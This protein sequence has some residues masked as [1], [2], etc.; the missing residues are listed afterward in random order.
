MHKSSVEDGSSAPV[1]LAVD[2][3]AETLAGGVYEGVLEADLLT[4][5]DGAGAVASIL[6]A[7]ITL[8]VVPS[9]DHFTLIYCF[10]GLPSHTIVPARPSIVTSP[11]ASAV[12]ASVNS[13]VNRVI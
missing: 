1:V 13:W 8:L 11:G 3:V 5:G 2:A 9:S 10:A 12:T 7:L 4:L 6:L